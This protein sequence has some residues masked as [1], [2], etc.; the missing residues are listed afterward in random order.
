MAG[1]AT[2]CWTAD[3]APTSCTGGPGDDIYRV[4]NIGDV[5]SEQTVPG[6]DD[7]G[8]DTVESTITYALPMFIERLTLKGTP[9]ING[10]GNNL[11]NRLDGNDAGQ[12]V[13][14]WGW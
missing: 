4:D 13:E 1:P 6:L 2:T 3:R 5:V 7:G 11:A 12:R 10:T 14:R 9:A 8:N